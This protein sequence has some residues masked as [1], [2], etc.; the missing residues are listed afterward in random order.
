MRAGAPDLAG[1]RLGAGH[2]KHLCTRSSFPITHC[3]GRETILQL[4]TWATAGPKVL[5]DGVEGL[6][7]QWAWEESRA[8]ILQGAESSLKSCPYVHLNALQHP[9]PQAGVSRKQMLGCPSL[10]GW[11]EAGPHSYASPDSLSWRQPVMD[12]DSLCWDSVEFISA[13]GSVVV[14]L[15]CLLHQLPRIYSCDSLSSSFPHAFTHPFFCCSAN[16]SPTP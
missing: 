4:D 16:H 10:P 5:R 9:W 2:Q 13:A 8:G 3:L 7:T 11:W 15:L 14:C 1:P 6:P 12:R